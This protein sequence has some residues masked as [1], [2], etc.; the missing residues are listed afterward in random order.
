MKIPQS[1]KK[2][3]SGTI[4]E[5]YQWEQELFDG[6]TKT[7][8]A[9]RRPNTALVIPTT[10]DNHV[11][12]SYEEQPLRPLSYTL[13]GGQVERGEDPLITGQRELLEESGFTSNDW[14][15]YLVVEPITSID[16][17]IYIYIARNCKKVGGQKL[18][19]GEKITVKQM[20]F[21]EFIDLVVSDD[22]LSTHFSYHISRLKQDP[23]SL[24]RFREKLFTA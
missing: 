15:E 18:D 4:Y 3:F 22:F 2:V 24:A 13:F 21:E 1:A 20:S 6:S 17:T 10:I 9:V 12:V 14:E 5:V 8:E 7:F 16:W 23:A 11:L 19:A